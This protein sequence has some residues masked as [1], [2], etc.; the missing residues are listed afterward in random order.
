MTKQ[1]QK[2]AKQYEIEERRR[3]VAIMAAQ[4]MTEIEIAAKLGVDNTTISKDI[5]ELKLI[6]QQFIY[7][8]TKSDFTYYYTQNLE[9]VKLVL[10]KQW[11]IIDK[12]GDIDVHDLHK[13]R[14]LSEILGTVETLNGYYDK[15]KHMHRT[16]ELAMYYSEDKL[17]PRPGAPCKQRRTV[18]DEIDMLKYSEEEWQEILTKDT[19]NQD[20]KS[21]KEAQESLQEIKGLIE[22]IK[23][24]TP[25]ERRRRIK[26][27]GYFA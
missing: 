5:K 18:E 25:D 7:D 21:V 19:A 22:R 14:F 8:I 27:E 9:L 3:Q 24:E 11:G 2:S 12:E 17:G 10:R 15:A 16:P 20:I 4:G 23:N 13:W 1:N 6:S 26:S